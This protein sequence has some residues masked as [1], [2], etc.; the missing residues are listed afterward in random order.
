VKFK[1]REK[2]IF[3]NLTDLSASA[4]IACASI[5]HEEIQ[6]KNPA[7]FGNFLDRDSIAVRAARLP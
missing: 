6:R 1:S 4:A 7:A 3:C 2:Q 5:Q